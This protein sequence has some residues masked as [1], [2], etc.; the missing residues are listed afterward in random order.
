MV[1]YIMSFYIPEEEQQKAQKIIDYYFNA[2]QKNGPAGMRSQCYEAN[3][4][5]NN[6]VHIK[7]F[8]KEATANHHF[9]SALFKE[10]LEKLENLSGMKL[11]FAKLYQQQTFESIY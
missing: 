9:K 11:S 2:L 7:S 10:Y 8:K 5:D 3:D 6:Y 1:R 4:D